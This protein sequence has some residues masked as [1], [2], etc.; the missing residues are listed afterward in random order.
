MTIFQALVLG[1]IQG[2]SEFLPISSSGHLILLPYLLRWNEQ[3]LAFDL[4]LHVGTSVALIVY[5]FRDLLDIAKALF[6]NIAQKRNKL[7]EYSRSGKYGLFALVAVIPAGIAGIVLDATLEQ[8]FRSALWVELFLLLGT[9]LMYVAE[10][11]FARIETKSELTLKK[12]IAIGLFEML[13]LLPGF[14]RSGSTISGGMIVGLSRKEAARFSFIMA[15]PTILGAALY[16]IYSSFES[17]QQLGGLLV[18]VGFLSSFIT[19][20]LA[21][22]FLMKFLRNNSLTTFIVYR[23]LIVLVLLGLFYVRI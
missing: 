21:I 16:K 6:F 13:A 14:S 23:I 15:I 3:S 1:T 11:R 18:V 4:V 19:G 9:I 5:F 20:I 17:L 12:S 8:V 22:S 10:K 2:L 7:Q